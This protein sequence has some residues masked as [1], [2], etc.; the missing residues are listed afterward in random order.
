MLGEQWAASNQWLVWHLNSSANDSSGNGNPG[1]V[2]GAT[3]QPIGLFGG[4]YSFADNGTDHI[5]SLNNVPANTIANVGIWFRRNGNPAA[6]VFL[7]QWGGGVAGNYELQMSITTSGKV[8]IYKVWDNHAITSTLLGNTSVC[9]GKRH[10]IFGLENTS[11]IRLYIDGYQDNWLSD[12]PVNN[13]TSAPFVLG[14]HRTNS[15]YALSC[16]GLID[17]VVCLTSEPPASWIK[18]WYQ[19]STKRSLF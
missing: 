5:V 14:C 19:Q 7:W 17:E 16:G 12:C 4:G 9:D 11:I 3:L 13:L 15:A 18:N 10:W 1:S 6:E 8:N 2:V